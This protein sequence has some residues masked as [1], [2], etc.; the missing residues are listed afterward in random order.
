MKNL[1]IIDPLWLTTMLLLTS[2]AI[3]QTAGEQ[4]AAD[5]PTPVAAARCQYTPAE[6][7][8]LGSS[9]SGQA[10]IT[11]NDDTT[12]AQL[13][14]RIPGPPV[15]PRR[16]PMGHPRGGYPGMWMPPG[17]SRHAA[18]GFLIGFGLGAAHPNDGTVRGHAALGLIGGLVGAVIGAGIPSF[19]V[20][21]PYRRG[22][23]P[24]DEDQLASESEPAKSGWTKKTPNPQ[25]APPN[26]A[27]PEST[28]SVDD[29]PRLLAE[30]P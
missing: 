19:H 1:R 7:A 24:E 22:P 11:T 30:T 6:S 10:T 13:P 25:T 16:P 3:A 26:P 27:P 5:L 18:I 12:V 4:A 23:W 15:R 14:R 17:N 28:A 21:N 20:R 2:A 8:C 9:E 29:R